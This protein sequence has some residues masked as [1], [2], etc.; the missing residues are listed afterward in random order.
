M[1]PINR[2]TNAMGRVKPP[3]Y[4]YA[5]LAACKTHKCEKVSDWSKTPLK[6]LRWFS[7]AYHSIFNIVSP[8]GMRFIFFAV[9]N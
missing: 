8:V 3:G 4:L 6:W 7:L 2:H 5:P 9:R 1:Q